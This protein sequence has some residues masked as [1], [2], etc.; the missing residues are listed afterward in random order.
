MFLEG[1]LHTLGASTLLCCVK[2]H[3]LGAGI[4]VCL[5]C[6]CKKL[7]L[8]VD[9]RMQL[10]ETKLLN[11]QSALRSCWMTSQRYPSSLLGK[12]WWEK[13]LLPTQ[14]SHVLSH[15][16][17]VWIP[18]VGICKSPLRTVKSTAIKGLF[19]VWTAYIS[20]IKTDVEE[21]RKHSANRFPPQS[22]DISET[23]A[24][25]IYRKPK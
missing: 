14:P 24:N 2:M 22:R 25:V 6:L 9:V 8:E 17:D 13:P 4:C 11:A 19:P 18:A 3:I 5:S 1:L 21:E 7:P 12:M 10:R 15:H 16:W 23:L 20:Q